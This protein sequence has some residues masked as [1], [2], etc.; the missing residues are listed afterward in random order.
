MVKY[1]IISPLYERGWFSSVFIYLLS[2]FIPVIHPQLSWK[3]LMDL[4][5]TRLIDFSKKLHI[6]LLLSLSGKHALFLLTF[7]VYNGERSHPFQSRQHTTSYRYQYKDTRTP[8]L[9][10]CR[11]NCN[12]LNIFHCPSNVKFV[13]I[14]TQE[15]IC[16]AMLALQQWICCAQKP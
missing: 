11:E 8:G 15:P 4:D 5:I 12:W 3:M 9:H 6:S 1:K 10:Y 7:H 13:W 2:V 16:L 14:W